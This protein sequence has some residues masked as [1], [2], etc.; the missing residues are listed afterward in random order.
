[1]VWLVQNC[2]S[3]NCL[4][5]IPQTPR[6]S[7]GLRPPGPPTRDLPSTR[8]GPNSGPQTPRLLTPPL[9][10]NPGPAPAYV[11][12]LTLYNA[13]KILCPIIISLSFLWGTTN[14]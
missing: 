3:N 12:M 9:T 1:M 8:W 13:A 5:V 11:H 6:A 7:G 14:V 10:T 4:S 2:R